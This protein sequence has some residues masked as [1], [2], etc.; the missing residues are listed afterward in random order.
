MDLWFWIFGLGTF[1]LDLWFR[2]F[3]L[4]FWFGNFC[5]EALVWELLSWIFGL[6][7]FVWELLFGIFGLGSLLWELLFGSLV[8]E[9]LFWG[10]LG[11]NFGQIWDCA[12]DSGP[13][14]RA[15]RFTLCVCLVLS[16]IRNENPK[17]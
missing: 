16:L 17:K 11:A 8:L 9:L 4:D 2:T 3:V 12:C 14:G 10:G 6:G 13:D 1:V 7:T 5:L 15:G